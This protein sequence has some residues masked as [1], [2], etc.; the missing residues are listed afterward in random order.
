MG[1]V[2]AHNGELRKDARRWFD[3]VAQL[4]ADRGEPLVAQAQRE[5]FDHV[6]AFKRS[7]R[8][9]VDEALQFVLRK[10]PDSL[11]TGQGRADSPSSH[12]AQ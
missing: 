10:S 9:D 1:R 7:G 5:C 4:V 6:I 11:G 2:F 3:L 12:A 8:A